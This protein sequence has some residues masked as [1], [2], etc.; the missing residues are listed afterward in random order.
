MEL[1]PDVLPLYVSN[2][3][4][5]VAIPEDLEVAT[6]QVSWEGGYLLGIDV[7][8]QL[9]FMYVFCYLGFWVAAVEFQQ[10]LAVKDPELAQ[11]LL[12]LLLELAEGTFADTWTR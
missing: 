4:R 10:S 2:D 9:A 7:K 11:G 12:I 3:L 8:G 6:V 1:P 5:E